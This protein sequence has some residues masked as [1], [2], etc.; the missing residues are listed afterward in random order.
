[1]LCILKMR[2]P[3]LQH[4]P[5]DEIEGWI[6]AVDADDARRQAQAAGEQELAAALYHA[7]FHFRPGKYVLP[8]GH[9]VLAS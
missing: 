8:T 5:G 9:I 7:P 3:S 4:Q 6:I 2:E 1:M